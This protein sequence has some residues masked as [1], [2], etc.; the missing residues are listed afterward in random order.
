MAKRSMT[1][2]ESWIPASPPRSRRNSPG[3]TGQCPSIAQRQLPPCGAT[4]S[5]QRTVNEPKSR[6]RSVNTSKT[7]NTYTDQSINSCS[8]IRFHTRLNS[9]MERVTRSTEAHKGG[10]PEA[11]RA[12]VT[13]VEHTGPFQAVNIIASHRDINS[14]LEA[15][16]L[17]G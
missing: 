7:T 5:E 11:A 4:S 13:P 12:M 8:W 3:K 17:P 16:E 6:P 9:S 1:G 10:E 2:K 14:K 15:Q